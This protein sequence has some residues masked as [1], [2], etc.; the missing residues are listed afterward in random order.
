VCHS[1]HARSAQ[2]ASP[3]GATSRPCSRS[4]SVRRRD[5]GFG[6]SPDDTRGGDDEGC[7]HCGCFKTT[8]NRRDDVRR[9]P[10]VL[11]LVGTVARLCRSPRD[12]NDPFRRHSRPVVLPMSV[13]AQRKTTGSN[14]DARR[15]G[16][17]LASQAQRRERRE[18]L[19]HR[20]RHRWSVRIEQQRSSTRGCQSSARRCRMRHRTDA[21]AKPRDHEPLNA[22]RSAPAQRHAIS[23]CA[24]RRR[25][26]HHAVDPDARETTAR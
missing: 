19:L 18:R 5:R 13:R 3:C 1:G 4:S 9:S 20:I 6:V 7:R 15:A 17:Q 24:P 23:R 11:A 21:E 26:R 8:I 22:S 14:R 12:A 16:N 10:L 2:C 25:E